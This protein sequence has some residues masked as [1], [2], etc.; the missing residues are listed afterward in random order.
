VQ[1]VDVSGKNDI[2][3]FTERG[4]RTGD[5]TEHELDMVIFAIGF[6][7][8]TGAL[9]EI[10]IRGQHGVALKS[11]W[12]SEIHSHLG[13]TV[14]GF[15]NM[16]MLTGPQSPFA[17][18]PVVIDNTAD[19]IGKAISHITGE[20]HTSIAPTK[21]AEDAW[22]DQVNDVFNMTLMKASAAD[23]GSWFVGANVKGKPVNVLFY[24]GGVANYIAECDRE[25]TAGFPSYVK[26]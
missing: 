11:L 5:G 8:A 22:A 26:A 7:A 9:D 18:M 21:A 3:E 12:K 10:D 19:W 17:N 4:F 20:N 23:T 2:R 1:L 24:F 13:I 25:A 14:N 16:F 15:P 6:D